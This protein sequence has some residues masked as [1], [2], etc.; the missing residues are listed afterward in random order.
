M[1]IPLPIRNWWA[2][3]FGK[4]RP[5][6]LMEARKNHNPAPSAAAAATVT[7]Y[8]DIAEPMD[9]E[10]FDKL[11]SRF[12]DR[13]AA[14]P[15]HAEHPYAPYPPPPGPPMPSREIQMRTIADIYSGDN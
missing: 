5:W 13:V 11:W 14:L 3:A 15:D 7:T 10:T 2:R 1:R 12:A 6:S 8:A 9:I 4:P